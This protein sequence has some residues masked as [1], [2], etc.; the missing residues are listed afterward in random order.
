MH[1]LPAFVGKGR[2][3]VAQSQFIGQCV[4]KNH[5]TTSIF[6]SSRKIAQ[7]AGKFTKMRRKEL[8]QISK[9]ELAAYMRLKRTIWEA[10]A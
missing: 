8:P 5:H 3:A 2:G 1:I 10:G 7:R 9:K 6:L 4:L